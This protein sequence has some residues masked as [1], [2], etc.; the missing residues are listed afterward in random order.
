MHG[1]HHLLWRFAILT[2]CFAVPA[3]AAEKVY[4]YNWTEY[5][6]QSVLEQFTKE[7]GIEVVYSTYDS[8]E[9]MYA[10]LKLVS[11]DGYDL[12]VPS[13]YYVN[14][15]GREGML[16]PLDHTLLPQM[17]DLDP[18]LLDRPFDPDN[19]YSIPYM[20]GSTGIGINTAEIP[21]D[22][23][24]SWADLWKPE[25]KGRLLLQDDMREVFHMALTMKGY[26]AN[27]RDQ[28]EI[29]TAYQLLR[30]L[31][32]NVLLFNSDS[33][34]LPYLAG[35]VSIGMI[36]NGEA[37]MAQQENP[38]I[39]YVYPREGAAFWVD[40]FVIPKGAR[41]VKN[42]HAFI[43]F[44]LRPDV[45][46]ACVEENGYATPVLSALPLLDEEVRTSPIIFPDAQIV[47]NGEFQTDVGEALPI[48]QQYW[49]R[50]RTGQ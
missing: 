13:T 7:T 12:A 37:W 43:N 48:Y 19:T 29:E 5:I 11:G 4:V 38:S 49:E 20:W 31:M 3:G 10:K 41:N 9:T 24:T 39:S 21:A 23:I 6:P 2:L 27:T 45:A 34:R 30:D 35:E 42:A 18:T 40:S 46:K 50:L 22:A 14:K 25:F 36:W 28:K 8:N 33:P 16:L 15:M 26:S 32:P 1:K 17:Q 47:N 44:M